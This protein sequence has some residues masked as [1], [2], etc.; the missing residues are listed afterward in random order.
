MTIAGEGCAPKA[1]HALKLCRDFDLDEDRYLRVIDEVG[2][3][4]ARWG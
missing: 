2:E 4:V 1:S 3:A